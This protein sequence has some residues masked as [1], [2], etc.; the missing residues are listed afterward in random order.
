MIPQMKMLQ[1]LF[2]T[3]KELFTG[4][5]SPYKSRNERVWVFV[6]IARI[7]DIEEYK[8]DHERCYEAIVYLLRNP[9]ILDI[10]YK[11]QMEFS[12]AIE[13]EKSKFMIKLIRYFRDNT[14][15]S[16]LQINQ[17]MSYVNNL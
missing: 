16:Y 9:D 13:I 17:L 12:D 2:Q 5:K 8:I 11:N 1:L 15:L 10:L 14:K 3:E 6:F 4:E 7:I